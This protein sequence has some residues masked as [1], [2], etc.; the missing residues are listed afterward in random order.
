MAKTKQVG[1]AVLINQN[2]EI[3]LLMRG[4]TAPTRALT[5]DLPGG[6]VGDDEDVK[7]STIREIEEE[8]TLKLD[9]LTYAIEMKQ[10]W[11]FYWTL[12]FSELSSGPEIKISW[13]HDKFIW[14]DPAKLEELADL[15]VFL[16]III[17]KVLKAR[18]Q[19]DSKETPQS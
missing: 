5:W 15:P 17:E 12:Y 2:G 13:E 16:R 18:S 7:A 1:K 6:V 14:C 9:D 8:T 4:K 19:S 11:G 3:L 10:P